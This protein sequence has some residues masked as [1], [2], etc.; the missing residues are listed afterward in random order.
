[1]AQILIRDLDPEVVERL[2]AQAKEHGRSLE[3]EVRQIL[4]VAVEQ[5]A[6]KDAWAKLDECR[7]RFAGQT[8]SDSTELIREDRDR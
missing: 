6:W 2:K 5:M 8:F 3:S 1:M 7:K 4:A